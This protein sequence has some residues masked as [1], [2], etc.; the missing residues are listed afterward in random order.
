MNEYLLS[1]MKK[2]ILIPIISM[3][4]IMSGVIFYIYMNNYAN[5]ASIANAEVLSNK[6]ERD[7]K[8][9]RYFV[10]AE[11]LTK[12]NEKIIF[13][14]DYSD[15]HDENEIEYFKGQLINV[16]YDENEPTNVLI[17]D[18]YIIYSIPYGLWRIASFILFIYLII[19]LINYLTNKKNYRLKKIGFKIHTNIIEI[20]K[21]TTNLYIYKIVSEYIDPVS[22]GKFYFISDK[23]V[24]PKN[25]ELKTNAVDV[26]VNPNNYEDYFVDLSFLQNK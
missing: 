1:I 20:R 4:L 11:F 14:A 7:G 13:T 9:T 8:Y 17:N 21:I 22:K 18:E 19:I 6:I 2:Y 25:Y 26:Y 24:I 23:V 3:I 16:I 15:L 12:N 10:E 5:N